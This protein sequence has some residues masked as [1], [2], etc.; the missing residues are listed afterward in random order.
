[1]TDL[2]DDLDAFAEYQPWQAASDDDFTVD[3]NQ[4]P[5]E[6]DDHANQLLRRRARLMREK[7]RICELADAET[8]RIEAWADDRCDGI[9]R[10]Q[11][12]AE[13]LL[14]DYMRAVAARDGVS[15]LQLPNGQ[16]K[17]R[18]APDSIEVYSAEDFI[19]WAGDV[20]ELVD[21]KRT[22][23]KATIKQWFAVGPAVL[24]DVTEQLQYLSV[25]NEA[26]TEII[27][28]VRWRR[29]LAKSFSIPETN[30]KGDAGA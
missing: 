27:P 9:D 11:A 13:K 12:W 23:R 1:M 6:H 18:K 20:E 25:V 21:V 7:Q 16:L 22:P 4:R 29:P 3:E 24:E 2:R 5:L 17:L 8:K 14:E 26:T 30:P 19:A 10:E 15:T 28:G